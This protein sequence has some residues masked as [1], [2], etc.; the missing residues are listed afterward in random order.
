MDFFLSISFSILS[1]HIKE[2]PM[3]IIIH[4]PRQMLWFFNS[5]LIQAIS[6]LAPPGFSKYLLKDNGSFSTTPANNC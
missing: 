2:P 6:T 1:F 4:G 5:G 3:S